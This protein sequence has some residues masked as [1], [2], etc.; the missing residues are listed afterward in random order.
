MSQVTPDYVMK[1]FSNLR[2]I[3][4]K[5]A[6]RIEVL[7]KQVAQ[8]QSTQQQP[9]PAAATKKVAEKAAA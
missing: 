1:E 3:T 4:R 8:L 7:E 6:M 9:P 5:Q 2:E